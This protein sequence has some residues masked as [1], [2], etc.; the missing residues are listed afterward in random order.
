MHSPSGPGPQAS[1]LDCHTASQ[2]ASHCPP[3]PQPCRCTSAAMLQG[4]QR[5]AGG[6]VGWAGD[7]CRWA[8]CNAAAGTVHHS[9]PSA[10]AP[11]QPLL[12]HR[13]TSPTQPGA[14]HSSCCL[15]CTGPYWPLSNAA[16][17]CVWA[18]KLNQPLVLPAPQLPAL[19]LQSVG[20]ANRMC[21]H[22]IGRGA[23][24]RIRA[25]LRKAARAAC[26]VQWRMRMRRR[27]GTCALI[28]TNLLPETGRPRVALRQLAA[29]L[30]RVQP[31]EAAPG[32]DKT[33][34][35]ATRRYG[36]AERTWGAKW[37][38]RGCTV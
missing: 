10:P 31:Q 36:S 4:R 26:M 32:K 8:G 25:L 37:Q 13:S 2:F 29:R 17:G 11:K 35:G 20:R 27:R 1:K 30:I 3:S 14:A 22:L 7:A 38:P 6:C 15:L 12:R 19:R 24:D 28:V 33:G 5:Q 23:G 16:P 21:E 9:A 18:H 34:S